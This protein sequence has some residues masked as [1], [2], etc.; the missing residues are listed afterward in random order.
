[1]NAITDHRHLSTAPESQWLKVHPALGISLMDHLFN[2]LD[3][4]YPNRWRASFPSD[5]AI[6][7]WAESWAEAFEDERLTPDEVKTGLKVCRSKHEWP[8]SVA[9]F[10]K[11]CRPQI[12]VDAA[13]YEACQQLRLRADGKDQ[14]SN[15]AFFWAAVKVGEF[16]MLNLSHTQLIKRFSAALDEVLREPVHPVP[17]RVVALPAPGKTRAAPERVQA[18]VEEV[19]AMQKAVG[20]KEWAHRILERIKSGEKLSIAVVDMAK[21]ALGMPIGVAA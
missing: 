4:A 11:A 19:K 2:R 16:D 13:L 20:N 17:P 15:P 8:P 6:A 18:A 3:G 9:E 5:Q 21:R 14:W 12:N 1:M 10:I 7:N